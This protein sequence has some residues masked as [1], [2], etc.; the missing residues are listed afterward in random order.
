[1]IHVK[2]DHFRLLRCGKNV[3]L[4]PLCSPLQH[5]SK[6]GCASLPPC[7]DASRRGDA[8]RVRLSGALLS[9][10]T[11]TVHKVVGVDAH[12]DFEDEADVGLRIQKDLL[13][14]RDVAEVAG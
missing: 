2:H 10:R 13:S 8:Q 6:A 7:I 4:I 12:E 1:M 5:K 14:V 3:D 11:L 9:W